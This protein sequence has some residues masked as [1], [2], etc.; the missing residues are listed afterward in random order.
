MDPAAFFRDLPTL[1][2]PRLILRKMASGDAVDVYAYA[3]DPDVT[4]YLPWE[5]HRSLYDARVFVASVLQRYEAGESAPWGIEL[6][7]DRCLI[8]AIEFRLYPQHSRGDLGYALRRTEWGK[9][10]TTEAV[11]AALAFGFETLRLNRI[12]ATCHIDNVASARVME[13]AGMRLEA[14]FRQRSAYHGV[15][16]DER[17]YAALGNDAR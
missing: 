10:Y 17:M 15:L 8:G 5:P 6:K 4:R 2:T 7:A 9:G 14:E 12:E 1:E 16:A 11:R 3:R 13:K